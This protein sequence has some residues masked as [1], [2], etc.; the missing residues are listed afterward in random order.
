MV[1][2][3]SRVILVVESR[4]EPM[5]SGGGAKGGSAGA[6]LGRRAAGRRPMKEGMAA[7]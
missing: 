5:T 7:C 3:G 4:G 6:H 1:R 2:R